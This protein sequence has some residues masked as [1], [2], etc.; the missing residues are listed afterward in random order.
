MNPLKKKNE[1][2]EQFQLEWRESVSVASESVS[3]EGFHQPNCRIIDMKEMGLP[4]PQAYFPF[5]SEPAFSIQQSKKIH[6]LND[7]CMIDMGDQRRLI[8]I[9][10]SFVEILSFA[11]DREA[12][13]V[14]LSIDPNPWTLLSVR[15]SIRVHVDGESYAITKWTKEQQAGKITIDWES[16]G[17]GLWETLANKDKIK[18]TFLQVTSPMTT[19]EWLTYINYSMEHLGY[20][21]LMTKSE[22]GSKYSITKV[23]GTEFLHLGKENKIYLSKSSNNAKQITKISFLPSFLLT[24]NSPQIWTF[25]SLDGNWTSWVLGPK[26][27]NQLEIW[28]S[29]KDY[30]GRS[31]SEEINRALSQPLFT[32][33]Q[34]IRFND[35]ECTIKAGFNTIEDVKL[36]VKKFLYDKY[37]LSVRIDFDQP[38]RTWIF[39]SQIPIVIDF[40]EIHTWFGFDKQ[41]YVAPTLLRGNPIDSFLVYSDSSYSNLEGKNIKNAAEHFYY[42][43][44]SSIYQKFQMHNGSFF[45]LYSSTYDEKKDS[46]SISC[47]WSRWV[48]F[49]QQIS[50]KS[51]FPSEMKY[52]FPYFQSH[53]LDPQTQE[54]P[55]LIPLN[56]VFCFHFVPKLFSSNASV[57]SIGRW[58]SSGQKLLLTSNGFQ[59]SGEQNKAPTKFQSFDQSWSDPNAIVM[60]FSGEEYS[61]EQPVKLIVEKGKGPLQNL[62]L[63]N[64]YGQKIQFATGFY[65]GTSVLYCSQ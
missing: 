52:N 39:E 29:A 30:D 51:M 40:G 7:L 49:D 45:H 59:I 34:I 8:P 46:L 41:K 24:S 47:A 37:M 60:C 56:F 54:K 62:Q 35:L 43:H 28:I 57:P 50:T 10:P 12:K 65:H 6:G 4:K 18:C 32:K 31:M 53:Q 25:P 19:A 64:I 11:F 58:I 3:I 2:L 21:H 27:W 17:S 23:N 26:P 20:Y 44:N 13:N 22:E 1:T 63:Y 38:T 14:T 55:A 42:G 9:I 48:S 5:A 33:D 16:S 61:L 15:Y 36:Y